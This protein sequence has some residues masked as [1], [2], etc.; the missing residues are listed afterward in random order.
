MFKS[1]RHGIFVACF[2]RHKL[3]ISPNVDE[4]LE[5]Y[6][7][8]HNMEQLHSYILYARILTVLTVFR[9]IIRHTR[10]KEGDNVESIPS[11]LSQNLSHQ[12]SI[13]M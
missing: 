10:V 5:L 3:C 1:S 7:I 8:F 12:R 4:E 9:N 13:I 2:C 6:Y 11:L